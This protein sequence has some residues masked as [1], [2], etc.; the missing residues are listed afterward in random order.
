MNK[1]VGVLGS[2]VFGVLVTTPL[3]ASAQTDFA[4]IS[5]RVA[6][7]DTVYVTDGEGRETR[8]ILMKVTP[9][10]LRVHVRGSE[11]E[12]PSEAVYRLERRGD[13]VKNGMRRGAIAGAIIGATLGAVAG[14]TWANSG[15]GST[16]LGGALG[17]G[18]VGTGFGVGIGAGMDALIPGRTLVY[19]K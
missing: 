2:V 4:S 16:A 17:L 14:A 3:P 7:G 11:G 19:R 8:G 13:S 12:W 6:P 18:L 1:T 5:K 9:S 15:S 10:A